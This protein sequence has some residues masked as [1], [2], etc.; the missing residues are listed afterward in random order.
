[1]IKENIKQL[2]MAIAEGDTMAIEDNFNSVMASKISDR[3]NDMRVSV[4]RG[5]FGSP[6]VEVE[7]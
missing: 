4:A 3:L 5:M 7:D 1:M 2:V 6:V